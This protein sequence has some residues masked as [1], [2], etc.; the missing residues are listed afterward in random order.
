MRAVNDQ[1]L[2]DLQNGILARVT[3]TVQLDPTLCLELRG[4]SINIYYRGGNLMK[5]EKTGT[6]YQAKFDS[7]YF[8]DGKIVEIPNVLTG[9]ENVDEWVRAWPILKKAV[10]R[11]IS[12]MVRKDEREVQQ[13]FVRANNYGRIEQRTNQG[14]QY[15]NGSLA[16]STDFYI[17][18]VEYTQSRE[19]WRFDMIAAHWPSDRNLRKKGNNRRLVIIEVKCGD[20][21]LSG[22][23]GLTEHIRDVDRFLENPENVDDLK[24]DMVRVFNQKRKLGLMDCDRD[25]K[26]FSDER[27]I[28]LLTLVNHDP[29]S[30]KLHE[31]LMN[32]TEAD[33]THMELRLGIASFFGY[34]LYDQGIHTI[35]EALWRFGDIVHKNLPRNVG[36]S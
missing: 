28:L 3:E 31:C 10:D 30:A 1:F 12:E 27:P 8:Q 34:G 24:K 11:Y 23:S 7:N 18:D 36:L 5:I 19:P 2:S 17:C 22:S 9:R 21:A 33:H 35:H 15:R 4:T 29:D 6:E 20:K 16:R 26:G 32:L 13:L 25:L 14:I